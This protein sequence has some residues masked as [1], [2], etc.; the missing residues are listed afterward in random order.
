[1]ALPTCMVTTAGLLSITSL[2]TVGTDSVGI[3]KATNSVAG[4]VS[5]M[6]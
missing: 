4:K 6:L 3:G 5:G 1:M 2:L